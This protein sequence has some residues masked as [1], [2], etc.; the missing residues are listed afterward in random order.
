[1]SSNFTFIL[2]TLIFP[3]LPSSP[4]DA[5]SI[6]PIWSVSQAIPVPNFY[7]HHLLAL[8]SAFR[9]EETLQHIFQSD[10][11]AIPISLKAIEPDRNFSESFKTQIRQHVSAS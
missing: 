1:M 10:H 11:Q 3:P 9:R 2:G 5:L 7:H 8:Q 6:I 4:G